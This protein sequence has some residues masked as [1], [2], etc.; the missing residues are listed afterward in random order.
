MQRGQEGDDRGQVSNDGEYLR[1]LVW[2]AGEQRR[3]QR[4]QRVLHQRLH[5]HALLAGCS[6]TLATCTGLAPLVCLMQTMAMA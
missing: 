3:R 6:L 1:S 4:D 5:A 2:G